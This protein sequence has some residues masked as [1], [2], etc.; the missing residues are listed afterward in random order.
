M[1]DLDLDP[2]LLNACS[3]DLKSTCRLDQFGD[4][5]QVLEC[6]RQSVGQL[7]PECKDVRV[8]IQPIACV[9]YQFDKK[10]FPSRYLHIICTYIY[11]VLLRMYSHVKC[12]LKYIFMIRN[13]NYII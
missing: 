9:V 8:L 3:K 6:L 13:C 12:E 11:H 5:L 10:M 2:Q 1:A 4:K 7:T